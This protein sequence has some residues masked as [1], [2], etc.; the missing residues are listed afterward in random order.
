MIESFVRQINKET[1][2]ML[3]EI[4]RLNATVRMLKK[5]LKLAATRS[6]KRKE[7]LGL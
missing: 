2:S 1:A 4:G 6:P 3:A 5:R 7:R